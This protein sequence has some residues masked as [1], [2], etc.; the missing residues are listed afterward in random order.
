MT[1]GGPAEGKPRADYCIFLQH[2]CDHISITSKQISWKTNGNVI[3]LPYVCARA[4]A[5][6]QVI[7]SHIKLYLHVWLVPVWWL[8]ARFSSNSVLWGPAMIL[9]GNSIK[10]RSYI[11]WGRLHHQ[12]GWK[13]KRPQRLKSCSNRTAARAFPSVPFLIRILVLCRPAL[14]TVVYRLTQ[15]CV[16]VCICVCWRHRHIPRVYNITG[17]ASIT[18]LFRCVTRASGMQ[19]NSR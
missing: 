10:V 18:R 1:N 15:M 17:P 14:I 8:H 19:H 9:C 11:N 12:F 6:N 13:V 16:C 7:F 2:N 3:R 4:S 5:I